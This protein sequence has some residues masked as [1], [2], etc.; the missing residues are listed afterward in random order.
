MEEEKGGVG[1]SDVNSWVG[2]GTVYTDGTSREK[3]RCAGGDDWI[4]LF[5]V[6]VRY[7]HGGVAG[8]QWL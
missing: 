8:R 7:T 5:E 2:R 3:N 6:P 4:V 1:V